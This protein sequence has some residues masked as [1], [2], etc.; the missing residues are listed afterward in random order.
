MSAP[1]IVSVISDRGSITGN[2][3]RREAV[4]LAN[5]LN[6]PLSVGLKRTSLSEVGPSLA[7]SAKQSSFLA[8]GIGTFLTVAFM[9][10]V[11]KFMGLIA[12][13]SVF[14]N[15]FMIVLKNGLLIMKSH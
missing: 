8:A 2:F 11:Y 7:D 5:A 13:V 15:I 12:V 10:L 3:T 1:N 6:N 14:A 4:E 9:I